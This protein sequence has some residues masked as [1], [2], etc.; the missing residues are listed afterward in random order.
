VDESPPSTNAGLTLT[1]LLVVLT[2]VSLLIAGLLYQAREQARRSQCRNQLK[3]I[4][5][6]FRHYMQVH[7]ALHPGEVIDN[8]G[9]EHSD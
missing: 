1:E 6:A 2:I 4:G 5:L 7:Q 8:K 9:D 3:N